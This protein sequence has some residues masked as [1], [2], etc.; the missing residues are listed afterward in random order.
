MTAYAREIL[1]TALS[2]QLAQDD[3]LRGQVRT[4]EWRSTLSNRRIFHRSLNYP[5]SPEINMKNYQLFTNP[6]SGGM[7]V[8]TAFAVAGVPVETIDVG[9][10]DL[11]WNSKLLAEHNPLGQIPTLILPDG[12][13]MTESAAIMLHL[14]DIKPESGLAPAPD[15][16]E[17]PAFLRWL[18]FIVAAVYPT[19][20]YG[21]VPERWVA[22]DESAANMLVQGTDDHRK[23][24]YRY[25]EQNTGTPWFLGESFSCI[26]LYLNVMRHWRPRNEWFEIEC[27]RLN[28][29]GLK[30]AEIPAVK[31]V[32]SR[33]FENE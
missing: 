21:D 14:A 5:P 26:D 23:T 15:Q 33:N 30:A 1:T 4:M 8:E 13:V 17:R 10:D 28:A 24:L 3:R 32:V 12:Q 16:P 7:I 11:G 31:R 18:M 6:G 19:F 2:S 9:W 22:A 29:V 25:L 27:P 20:T